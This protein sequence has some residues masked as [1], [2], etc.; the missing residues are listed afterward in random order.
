MLF[1]SPVVEGPAQPRAV[2]PSDPLVGGLPAR[3]SALDGV[4]LTTAKPE[5]RLA[6]LTSTADGEETPLL[7]TWRQG[8]GQVLAFTSDATG[9]WTRNWQAD[10][11][12]ATLWSHAVNQIRPL[13]PATGP[14]LSM[15]DAGEEIVLTL[16]AIDAEGAPRTGL[17]PIVQISPEGGKQAAL[18]MRETL[19]GIY[20][21]AYTPQRLGRIGASVSLPASPRPGLIINDTTPEE[22][23]EAAL[24]RSRPLWAEP[25]ASAPLQIVGGVEA[26][27][28]GWAI[29][30]V[31]G[32]SS[33]WTALALL[34]F[35][36]ALYF[37]MHPPRRRS[38]SGS[39][40][41]HTGRPEGVSP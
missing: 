11:G 18:P 7:A 28:T 22:V 14:W 3:L 2:D 30:L 33:P 31:P 24:Y 23:A 8:N 25:R 27:P 10:P 20:K 21:A 37:Y 17:A 41:S 12:F 26:V 40:A 9:P 6:L 16:E 38:A 36:T 35:L 39:T 34:A 13:R 15:S 4:V 19:P 1:S 32:L 29:R 5:A